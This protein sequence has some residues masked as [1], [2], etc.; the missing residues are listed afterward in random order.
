MTQV[1]MISRDNH[2]V[3]E[4]TLSAADC[5]VPDGPAH[6]VTGCMRTVRLPLTCENSEI[7]CRGDAIVA[8]GLGI[9]TP[10]VGPPTNPYP[11]S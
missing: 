7:I 11:E 3:V 8:D 10:R 5:G 6:F 2:A 4:C 9:R 1:E